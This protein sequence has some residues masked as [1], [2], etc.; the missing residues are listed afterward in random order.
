PSS[1]PYVQPVGQTDP[2]A[3]SPRAETTETVGSSERRVPQWAALA[4]AVVGVLVLIAIVVAIAGSSEDSSMPNSGSEESTG[5]ATRDTTTTEPPTTT[6]AAPTTGSRGAP[7]ALGTVATLGD[8]EV[9]VIGFQVDANAAMRNENMFNDPA[10][11]GSTYS[12]VRVRATYRGSGDDSASSSIGVG[13]VGSDNR[14]YSDSDC[15]AVEPNA[16]G[17]QPSVFSGG[18]V[19]GNVCLVIPT[20]QIPTGVIYVEDSFSFEDNAAWWRTS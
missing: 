10:P 19:E 6:T 1:D 12:L 18:S 20:A 15:M 7:L 17:D 13:F 5:D 2:A 14:K 9:A 3:D 16:L 8:W 4:G 11:A